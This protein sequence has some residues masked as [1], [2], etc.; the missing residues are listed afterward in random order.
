VEA[1]ID[2]LLLTISVKA[3]WSPSL[4]NSIRARSD[5]F[6]NSENTG[7]QYPF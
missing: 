2:L 4:V 5:R 3:D 6:S 1:I 7:N